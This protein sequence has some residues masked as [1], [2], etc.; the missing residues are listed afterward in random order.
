MVSWLNWLARLKCQGVFVLV[1]GFLPARRFGVFT[2]LVLTLRVV[3][4]A[5][6]RPSL[7]R[8]RPPRYLS[9]LTLYDFFGR[10][11]EEGTSGGAGRSS[12]GRSRA[13]LERR[14]EQVDITQLFSDSTNELL[15]RAARQA[16]EWGV[17]I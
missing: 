5:G 1:G 17:R 9:D 12:A 11:F 3:L 4:A 15:Q 13:V 8:S 16:A 10:F 6:H 14:V 7:H 2:V